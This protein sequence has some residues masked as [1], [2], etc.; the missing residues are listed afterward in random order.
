MRNHRH[1]KTSHRQ[2][3]DKNQ[4][5]GK[6]TLSFILLTTFRELRT[7]QSA[8]NP[9]AARIR[10]NAKIWRRA[11]NPAECNSLTECFNPSIRPNTLSSLTD[12]FLRNPAECA[13]MAEYLNPAELKNLATYSYILT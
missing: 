9:P 1:L 11:P 3:E 6:L 5:S 7:H 10:Q 8:T 2:H 4:D 12:G 13:N